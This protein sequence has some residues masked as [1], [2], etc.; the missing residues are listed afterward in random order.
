MSL[1]KH[2]KDKLIEGVVDKGY[3]RYPELAYD[4]EFH[5]KRMLEEIKELTKQDETGYSIYRAMIM[6]EGD[7]KLLSDKQINVGHIIYVPESLWN[8]GKRELA[9]ISNFVDF[10]FDRLC[11]LEENYKELM[12]ENE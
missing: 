3:H 1:A 9:D 12:K 2:K 4:F 6:F 7:L 11:I 8:K 10:L 5:Y